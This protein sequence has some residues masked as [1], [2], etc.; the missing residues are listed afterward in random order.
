M[1]DVEELIGDLGDKVSSPKKEKK[2]DWDEELQR[3]YGYEFDY[4]N[5]YKP[6]IYGE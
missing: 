2:D 1:I 6:W 4:W 5:E 3:R